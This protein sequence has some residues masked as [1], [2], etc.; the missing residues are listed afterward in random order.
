[1][2]DDLTCPYCG[3][4]QEAVEIYNPD[5][6][7]RVE[8]EVCENVYTVMVGWNPVYYCNEAPCLN[9]GEHEMKKT[10]RAPRVING[11]EKWHCMTCSYEENRPAKCAEDC[12]RD[13]SE[14][15]ECETK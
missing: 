7:Y 1:M 9:G 13:K 6:E 14:C 3:N 11:C 4:Q 15:W 5:E 12:A 2:N 10:I 8:G